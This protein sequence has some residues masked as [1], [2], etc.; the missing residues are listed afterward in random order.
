MKI[1]I[2][3]TVEFEAIMITYC[4]AT[5]SDIAAILAV[6]KAAFAEYRGQLEP[7]SSAERKTVE[8]VRQELSEAT[9]VLAE[10]D[11]MLVGCVF[12]RPQET[13]LYLDRLAVLPAWRRQGIAGRLID[14]VEQVAREGGYRSVQL[15]VRVALPKNHAYYQ[16]RG[17]QFLHYN[18]H[19]GYSHP[20][21]I[22][23]EKAL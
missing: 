11:T 10:S 19:P 14:W 8:I 15:S 21:S 2:S 18:T 13:Y 16:Q 22:T 3:E 5:E 7:P 1:V 9:A 20:T 12:Y 23:F 6:I 4:T 17:Y